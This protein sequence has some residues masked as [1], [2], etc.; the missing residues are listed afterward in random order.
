MN[1]LI[2]KHH[3]KLSSISLDFIRGI[4]DEIHWN[5]RLI[6]IRSERSW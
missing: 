1:K 3:K 5:A 4:M 2:E 6:G